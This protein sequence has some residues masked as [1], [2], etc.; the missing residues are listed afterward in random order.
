MLRQSFSSLASETNHALVSTSLCVSSIASFR[1]L[2]ARLAAH[3][4]IVTQTSQFELPKT[5]CV[6][7]GQLMFTCK[8]RY[9]L[10]WGG[11]RGGS[12]G[13]VD[14][15]K[16]NVKTYN[17]RVVKKQVNH[18]SYG[19]D[20]RAI[21][22]L[23]IAP[24]NAENRISEA[25]KLKIFGGACPRTPLGATAFGGRLSEPRFVKSWIRP[26]FF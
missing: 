24:E 25:I 6:T 26:S 20:L 3:S 23:Q 13:S 9:F 2:V 7:E 8:S 14:P 11:S 1:C 16:L 17:K 22:P 5:N 18:L 15:P 19:G 12:G 10:F 4:L 21:K